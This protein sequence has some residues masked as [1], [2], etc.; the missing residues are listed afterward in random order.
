[1]SPG[2]L[3]KIQFPGLQLQ[4]YK[5]AKL[6]EAPFICNTTWMVPPG[7]V[8]CG[9]SLPQKDWMGSF[10]FL[11]STSGALA[12]RTTV[13]ILKERLLFPLW[14]GGKWLGE[15]RPEPRD[16]ELFTPSPFHWEITNPLEKSEPTV[17]ESIYWCQ[18]GCKALCG[19][20]FISS[21]R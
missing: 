20:Y 15:R 8:Q 14:R 3:L 21:L 9:S 6:Q 11:T 4:N 5:F 12:S 17:I 2:Y 10:T 7:V 19:H 13:N 1:M 16:N 18:A